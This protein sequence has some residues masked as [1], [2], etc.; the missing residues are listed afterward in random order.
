MHHHNHEKKH[1]VHVF[2]TILGKLE[3]NIV[4]FMNYHLAWSWVSSVSDAH[5]VKIYD[6]DNVL[7]WTQSGE[8]TN[9]YY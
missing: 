9:G 1:T 4:E 3:K 5:S 8:N 7:V 6:C 2:R